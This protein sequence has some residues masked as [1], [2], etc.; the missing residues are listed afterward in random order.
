MTLGEKLKL[1]RGEKGISQE[2]LAEELS[3]SRSAIAKW[4]SNAGIPEISNL[5]ALSK[6]FNISIDDLIDTAQNIKFEQCKAE[7]IFDLYDGKY[8]DI[9]LAGWNDG[10]SHVLIIGED[11]DFLFYRKTEKKR[12]VYGLIGKRYITEINELKISNVVQSDIAKIDRTYFCE[13]HVLMELAC[14]EGLIEGFFDF[15]NDDYLD[16]IINSFSELE[17]QL[18]FGQKVNISDITKI[19]EL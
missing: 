1:L 13:K 12:D 5:K 16:V 2:E 11:K 15:R 18:R 17:I 3:V 14:K 8:Y 10:V 4:E 7:K 6:V 9:E 19:Q